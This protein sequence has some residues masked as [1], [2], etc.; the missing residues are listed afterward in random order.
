M[1][2]RVCAEGS[3]D[4]WG[5]GDDDGVDDGDDDGGDDDEDDSEGV[6]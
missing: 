6:G 4:S 2:L 5:Y 3:G 1:V